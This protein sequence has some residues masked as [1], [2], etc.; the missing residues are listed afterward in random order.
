MT[1]AGGAHQ[2]PVGGADLV[3]RTHRERHHNPA[4]RRIGQHGVDARGQ[5]G[6][7]AVLADTQ[8]AR[9]PCEPLCRLRLV[10]VAGGPDIARQ[11]A[12][13]GIAYAV[14]GVAMRALE[15]HR[16][17]PARAG[18]Q[19]RRRGSLLVD[20]RQLNRAGE[21]RNRRCDRVDIEQE[22]H[23]LVIA[24][25]QATNGALNFKVTALPHARQAHSETQF[26]PPRRI[27]KTSASSSQ[28]NRA[29]AAAHPPALPATQTPHRTN[30]RAAHD[31]QEHQP[32]TPHRQRR[33]L[34]QDDHA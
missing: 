26:G 33:L 29:P 10:H 11:Q 15:P 3:L 25:R 6:T 34:L 1:R 16:Q 14:I 21:M 7:P 20:P 32:P 4:M 17:T 2:R 13:F 5:R 28:P 12:R 23:A 9:E 18:F 30:N 8:A 24:V 27:A 19:H 31:Q 22:S